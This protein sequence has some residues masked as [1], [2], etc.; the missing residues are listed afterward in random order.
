MGNSDST[1][2]VEQLIARIVQLHDPETRYLFSGEPSSFDVSNLEFMRDDAEIRLHIVQRDGGSSGEIK[3]RQKVIADLSSLIQFA[4]SLESYIMGEAEASRQGLSDSMLVFVS[5]VDKRDPYEHPVSRI[6][7]SSAYKWAKQEYQVEVQEWT[8]PVPVSFVGGITDTRQLEEGVPL[9]AQPSSALSD[10]GDP[11]EDEAT[12]NTEV[13]LFLV[14]DALS[15]QLNVLNDKNSS[16][17]DEESTFGNDEGIINCLAMTKY[18]MKTCLHRSVG[19]SPSCDG[20]STPPHAPQKVSEALLY[21]L[22]HTLAEV[23]DA[24][25]ACGDLEVWRNAEKTKKENFLKR[26]RT[27]NTVAIQRYLSKYILLN[28]TFPA[29]AARAIQERLSNAKEQFSQ[30]DLSGI[31]EE[32]IF[33]RLKSAA[34]Q[35]QRARPES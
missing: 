28:R 15:R 29:Q 23:L 11:G 22:T 7:K 25:T 18:V 6:V 8:M 14:A 24:A 17:T 31:G 26:D 34:E 35:Y 12:K 16:E 9:S 2:S 32:D 33:N 19:E 21:L 5:S 30:Q 4:E 10:S 27:F 20:H 13:T 3:H 1:I